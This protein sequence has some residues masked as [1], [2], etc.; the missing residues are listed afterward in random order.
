MRLLFLSNF[1][2][3]YHLGGLEAQCYEIAVELAARGHVVHILTSRH[4]NA[5]TTAADRLTIQR[6]LHLEMA[7]GNWRNLA[8]FFIG[9]TRRE[10]ANLACLREIVAD[11]QPDAIMAW[12]MWNLPR[13]L[14]ALAEALRPQ[15]T[16]Y[17]FGDYWPTLPSQW[18]HY[19]DKLAPQGPARWVKS[20]LQPMA[21]RQI[22]HEPWPSLRY[23]HALFAS[24]FIRMTL[25]KAGIH[26]GASLVIPGGVDLAPFQQVAASRTPRQ[27]R[28]P[29]RALVAGRLIQDKGAHTAIEAVAILRDQH[30]GIRI[31]LT[32]VGAGDQRYRTFLYDLAL[33]RGISDRVHFAG[34]VPKEA[35]P[36]VYRKHDLLIFP[37]IWPEPFG[38]VLVEAMA[39][40]LPVIGTSVGGN[41][42]L[43]QEDR[44]GLTFP[45]E[46]VRALADLMLRLRNERDLRERL[47]AQA[48]EHV[49]DRFEIRVM[50]LAIEEYLVRHVVT[51]SPADTLEGIKLVRARG[52]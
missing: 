38:L 16:V 10:Q 45:P 17:Y 32:L 52:A 46:N 19:W 36:E 15:Q 29:W 33:A 2:P 20:A 14:P 24:E 12:G 42:D 43:L 40:G 22:A 25:V 49:R 47:S 48:Q 26:P 3:P 50:S 28:D 27:E 30:P 21:L 31:D 13:S 11:V 1:L 35:M 37:S 44:T 6:A 4:G 9:R 41:R 23:P 8:L 5:A 51:P 18:Q 34:W 39:A 7:L